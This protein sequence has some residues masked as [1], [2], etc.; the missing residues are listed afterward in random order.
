MK[1]AFVGDVMLGDHPVCFGHGV[2]SQAIKQGL[3]A[4]LSDASAVFREHDAVIGNLETVLS[5]QGE[6]PRNLQALEFR[7]QPSFAAV[8]FESGFTA[9]SLANNH[10]LEHGSDA[11]KET[12]ETLNIQGLQVLG[13]M[14]SAQGLDPVPLHREPNVVVLACSMRPEVYAAKNDHY[15]QPE[16]ATLISEVARQAQTDRVVIVSLH[17]GREYQSFPSPDQRT[18]AHALIDAGATLVVGHHPHVMQPVESY[19]HGLIAYSLGNFLFDSWLPDCKKSKILSVELEGRNIKHWQMHAFRQSAEHLVAK[20]TAA[21]AASDLAEFAALCEQWKATAPDA[22]PD[23]H[24]Y[25]AK[26]DKAERQYSHSSYA[27]FL[28]NLTRYQPW[29]IRQSIHRALLRKLPRWLS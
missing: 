14:G 26:A 16:A 3:G 17:W 22:L 18:L 13:L 29:V 23:E 25:Q 7:G 6:E 20:P 15:A 4:L 11:F 27:Y 5:A 2:R 28:R 1:L 24:S 21:E 12:V 19:S 9:L 10:I 8:L